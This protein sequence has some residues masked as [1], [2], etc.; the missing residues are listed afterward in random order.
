MVGGA[1][2]GQNDSCAAFLRG[3]APRVY[4]HAT[5][6]VKTNHITPSGWFSS[7]CV[8]FYQ[9]RKSTRAMG[10]TGRRGEDPPQHHNIHSYC[11]I[12]K[13]VEDFALTLELRI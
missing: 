8:V 5:L 1:L 2:Q 3:P 4:M 6:I 10:L 13:Y 9:D 7:L 11:Q 12:C